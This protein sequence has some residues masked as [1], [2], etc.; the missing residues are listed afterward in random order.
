M[1]NAKTEAPSP[2]LRSTLQYKGIDVVHHVAFYHPPRNGHQEPV[3]LSVDE[4]RKAR[5][6]AVE[7]WVSLVPA[8]L[9]D[10][11]GYDII[12][13]SLYCDETEVCDASPLDHFCCALAEG[14]GASYSPTR[15]VKSRTTHPLQGLGGHDAHLHE[16]DNVFTFNGSGLTGAARVLIVDDIVMT[17]ATIEAIATA[18]HA[19]LPEARVSVF[20]LACADAAMRNDHLNPAYFDTAGTI[21]PPLSSA[22]VSQRGSKKR[23]ARPVSHTS[24]VSMPAVPRA[25]RSRVRSVIGYAAVVGIAALLMATLVP[26]HAN[27]NVPLPALAIVEAGATAN[28]SDELDRVAPA[29]APLSTSPE[30]RKNPRPATVVVPQVGLRSD[31]SFDSRLLERATAKAGETVEIVRRHVADHGP[32]WYLIRIRSGKTGWVMAS[33]V[34]RQMR[35]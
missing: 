18:V 21:V 9:K 2:L 31:H 6:R 5:S 8:V 10:L 22:F 4:F 13:R 14:S 12:L 32:D 26:L 1:K 30:V 27:K 23:V 19:A 7:R 29:A 35:H 28:P 3:S 15:L 34:S 33:V 25:G 20:V 24:A 16:L 11:N 17:G